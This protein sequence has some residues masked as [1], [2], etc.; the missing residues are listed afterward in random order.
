MTTHLQM[1]SSELEN[2][3]I[4]ITVITPTIFRPGL[5][6]MCESID[7]QNYPN[8]QHVIVFDGKL[9]MS[10]AEWYAQNIEQ[11]SWR[12]LVE[13]GYRTGDNGHTPRTIGNEHASKEYVCYQD[14]DDVY[15]GNAFLKID[16]YLRTLKERPAILLFPGLYYG[17]YFLKIPPGECR[18]LSTQYVHKRIID[19]KVVI[20][21]GDIDRKLDSADSKWIGDMCAQYGYK[22]IDDGIP[23]V[24]V[25]KR[26]YGK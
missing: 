22:Y 17:E 23:L 25:E 1:T 12:K 14:D 18:T 2:K 19:G 3:Y 16:M 26:S 6:E 7:R 20:F 4:G 13:T 10:D 24:K 15:I 5:V 9:T 11:K 21:C 8:L